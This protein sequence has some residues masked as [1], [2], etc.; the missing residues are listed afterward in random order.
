MYA[1][2]WKLS[3][4]FAVLISFYSH[5]VMTTDQLLTLLVKLA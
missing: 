2:D 5:G 4:V 3:F 1:L